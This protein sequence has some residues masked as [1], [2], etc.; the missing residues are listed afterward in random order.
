MF[1]KCLDRARQLHQVVQSMKALVTGGGGFVGGY[2]V[3]RLL[4]RGYVVRS[5]GRSSQPE[6]KRRG[7]EVCCGDLVCFSL[8]EVLG[9]LGV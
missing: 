1:A 9:C 7:V 5:F 6:L 2:V 4:A 8:S 3:E